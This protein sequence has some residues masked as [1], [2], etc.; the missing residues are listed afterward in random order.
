MV[1]DSELDYVRTFLGKVHTAATVKHKN[2]AGRVQLIADTNRIF[3]EPLDL[4]GVTRFGF[5]TKRFKVT[6]SEASEADL[7]TAL[8]NIIDGIELLN[9]RA[10]IS[11][12]TRPTTLCNARI[13]HGEKLTFN[14]KSQRW[15][16]II[17]IDFEWSTS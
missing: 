2:E 15:D 16:I 1:D 13:A 11:E 10:T 3:V 14:K 7:T 5:Y 12:Y 17:Y 4:I 9:R 8:N 6:L